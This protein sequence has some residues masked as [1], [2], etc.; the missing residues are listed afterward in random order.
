[1]RNAFRRIV[2]AT[3]IITGLALAGLAATPAHAATT[4]FHIC[5]YNASTY[6]LQTNGTGQQVT[7]TG[8]QFGYANFSKAAQKVCSGTNDCYQ[9]K[10]GNGNCLRAADGN[11]V[12][13]ENG[14]CVASDDADWW[15][16]SNKYFISKAYSN[17]M[18]TLT[19]AGGANVYHM[20][21][22]SGTWGKWSW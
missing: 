22:I 21:L 4:T 1:M 17:Y 5:L 2:F 7:I 12:K 15:I 8:S 6:C 10:D 13:I 14:G 11:E 16:R 18:V 9:F 19:N 20:S 3:V